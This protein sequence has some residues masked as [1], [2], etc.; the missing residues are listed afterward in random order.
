M[1]LKSASILSNENS[2]ELF[3]W[4]YIKWVI[5]R[6]WPLSHLIGNLMGEPECILEC[7]KA[8]IL[9]VGK[10]GKILVNELIT[11]PV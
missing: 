5:D 1:N 9:F 2:R 10:H 6:A 11:I 7:K 3:W 8:L 4:A